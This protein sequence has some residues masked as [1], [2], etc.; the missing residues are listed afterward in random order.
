MPKPVRVTVY[1]LFVLV[2]VFNFVQDPTLEGT[3]WVKD[4][5]GDESPGVRYSLESY[6]DG[7]K[8][9]FEGKWTLTAPHR[10]V[11]IGRVKFEILHPVNGSRPVIADCD[12]RE[13]VA[14]FELLMKLDY[15]GQLPHARASPASPEF[16][17]NPLATIVLE[18]HRLSADEVSTDHR[19]RT[20]HW[21]WLECK[22]RKAESQQQNSSHNYSHG[23]PP[24]RRQF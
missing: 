4:S 17:Q 16:K 7:F 15:I 12:Q 19:I 21:L 8:T 20:V 13:I 24:L 10:V 3:L 2:Y 6:D 23:C 5:A 14:V 11:P 22:C 18:I 9:N 1:L